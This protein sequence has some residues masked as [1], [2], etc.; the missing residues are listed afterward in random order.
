MAIHSTQ[1]LTPSPK[2]PALQKHALSAAL[3]AGESALAM[4]AAQT[5]AVVDPVWFAN[6]P[7]SHKV[8]VEAP[9]VVE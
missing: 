3:P 9:D 2:K 7:A 1:L 5:A 8:H 6:F 4:H